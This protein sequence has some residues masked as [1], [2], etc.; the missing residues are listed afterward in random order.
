MTRDGHPLEGDRFPGAPAGARGDARLAGLL[1]RLLWSRYIQNCDSDS[2]PSAT[3][4]RTT[5][6][7]GRPS[8]TRRAPSRTQFYTNTGEHQLLRH[9]R[10]AD[11]EIYELKL[12]E[13]DYVT[14]RD[15]FCDDCTPDLDDPDASE[16]FFTVGGQFDGPATATTSSTA[17]E[18]RGGAHHQPCV[19]VGHEL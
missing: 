15:D 11:P 19:Q 14:S 2:T 5:T 17:I 9:L 7:T 12:L 13:W 4:T 3:T 10:E 6:T 16:V 1:A 18:L 8:R